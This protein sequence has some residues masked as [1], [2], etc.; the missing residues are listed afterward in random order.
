MIRNRYTVRIAVLLWVTTGL[1]FAAGSQAQGQSGG[2]Y[3]PKPGFAMPP[4][5][6]EIVRTHPAFTAA[7]PPLIKAVRHLQVPS[8]WPQGTQELSSLQTLNGVVYEVQDVAPESES[9]AR[10]AIKAY[11]QKVVALG[12][13]YTLFLETRQASTPSGLLHFD[14]S[15]GEVVKIRNIQGALFPMQV[16]NSL[17]LESDWKSMSETI[18]NTLEW[19]VVSVEDATRMLGGLPG[20]IYV[21]QAYLDG[22]LGVTHLYSDAMQYT[23]ASSLAAED[24]PREEGRT[25]VAAACRTWP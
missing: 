3:S 19:R 9:F 11:R 10:H 14:R 6:P 15:Q 8:D 20:K 25:E 18:S 21:V 5:P 2:P 17:R 22:R 24:P 23:I 7:P 12:G 13:M 16:G 4:E 1:A